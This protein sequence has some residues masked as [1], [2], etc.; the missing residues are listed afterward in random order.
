MGV[1]GGGRGGMLSLFELW[2]QKR[3]KFH[4]QVAEKP[5]EVISDYYLILS[6]YKNFLKSFVE[7][8][9]A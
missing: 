9:F 2:E 7:K 3:E 8:P 4:Q 6:L 5:A 1:T